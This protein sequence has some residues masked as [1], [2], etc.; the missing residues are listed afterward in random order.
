MLDTIPAP[1]RD[2]MEIIELTGYTDEEK[3]QIARRY[4]LPRQ[5]EGQRPERP[6]R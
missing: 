5:L 2:R 6:S 4:L 1:L 3:L